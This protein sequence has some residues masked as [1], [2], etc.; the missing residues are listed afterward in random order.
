MELVRYAPEPVEFRVDSTY[1]INMATGKFRLPRK[2]K[3]NWKLVA[4]LRSAYR[5]LGMYKGRSNVNIVHVR[6]HIGE[7]GNEVADALAKEGT[8]YD[9]EMARNSIVDDVGHN[10]SMRACD[11]GEQ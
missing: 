10:A 7:L 4:R 2:G 5:Q 6:S 9:V 1:A 3:G 11:K 8:E